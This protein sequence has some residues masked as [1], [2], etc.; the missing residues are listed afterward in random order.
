MLGQAPIDY[1]MELKGK[2]ARICLVG[3]CNRIAVNGTAE[4]EGTLGDNW[5]EGMA[6]SCELNLDA[7]ELYMMSPDAAWFNGLNG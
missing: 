1:L 3:A 5:R 6:G 4:C 2:A 7:D